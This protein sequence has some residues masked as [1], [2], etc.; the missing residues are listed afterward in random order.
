M[1]YAFF[2]VALF[3]AAAAASTWNKHYITWSQENGPNDTTVEDAVRMWDI[4]P[5][6]QLVR[7]N[8]GE[9]DIKI[10]FKSMRPEIFGQA[11]PPDHPN[12]GQ[13]FINENISKEYL[14]YTLQHELGHSLGLDHYANSV[15]EP[16]V[17]GPDVTF[18]MRNVSRADLDRLAEMYDCGFD[19]V[20][21]IN[22]R[23]YLVFRGSHYKRMDYPS[24][25]TTDDALWLPAIT[26]VDAMYRNGSSGDYYIVSNDAFYVFDGLMRWTGVRGELKTLFPN[27][28]DDR[29]DAVLTYRNGSAFAVHD[30][31]LSDGVRETSLRLVFTPFVPHAKIKGAYETWDGK[32]VL[33]DDT[34]NWIYD[35]TGRLSKRVPLCTI[36]IHCC[37]N[38]DRNRHGSV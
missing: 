34:H 7:V 18:P 24:R 26:R 30:R 31:H 29:V 38:T 16:Y 4:G 13:V 37:T 6:L 2:A 36:K 12:R 9:G 11:Y 27:V 5:S 15:M 1:S 8:P 28:G 14:S 17:G 25:D 33:V 23:T 19:S 32:T 21:L 22:Y 10:T 20:A 3:S 35:E